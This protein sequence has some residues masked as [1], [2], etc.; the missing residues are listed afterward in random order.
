MST[1]QQT[2]PASTPAAAR[3]LPLRL[4]VSGL[5]LNL[6]HTGTGRY[7]RVVIDALLRAP[8][9]E[10]VVIG[11]RAPA[12]YQ[13][14]RVVRAPG[15]PVGLGG[16]GDK[17][18]WEQVGLRL[19]AWRMGVDVLYSPHFSAP[20][21][22]P[23][24]TVLSVHDMIPLT[25]REYAGSRAARAY[26]ALVGAAARQAAAVITLSEHARGEIHRLLSIPPERVHVV[27]PGV[28]PAF[29][30]RADSEA[31]ARARL[32]LGLPERYL[33]YVGGADARK[34]IG[35][36]LE[37]M[38]AVGDDSAVPPLV[39]AAGL[40]KQGQDALF[41]DWRGMARA[42]GLSRVQFVE[43]IA[44]EDLP[45]V[46]RGALAFCFPSRAEGFGLTPLEAMACGTPVLCS[47]AS[48]LP[49]A[50]GDAAVLLPPHDVAAWATAIRS[51]SRDAALRDDLRARGMARAGRFRW[52]ETSTRVSSIIRSVAACAS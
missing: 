39:I 23:W 2:R 28:E 33:L 30:A 22:S 21:Y 27:Y 11:D 20:L 19:A 45:A 5:F 7:A 31:L 9:I 18:Y 8:D 40:P 51:I 52:E 46:Y 37:A 36:L 47:D 49:E 44:E 48:C 14:M 12:T 6:P 41:P 43:R 1:A 15:P 24:P 13:G 38:A 42:L 50:A 17:L 25:E 26:F 10:A 4:A 29:T 35:V 3:A 32:R 16:Y 34:N